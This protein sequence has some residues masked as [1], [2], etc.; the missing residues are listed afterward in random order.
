MFSDWD[1][2]NHIFSIYPWWISLFALDFM[3]VCSER[4]FVGL[5]LEVFARVYDEARRFLKTDQ[6]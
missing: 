6:D 3:H 5:A 1:Y 2:L 4:A